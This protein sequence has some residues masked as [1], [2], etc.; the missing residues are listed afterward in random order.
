MVVWKFAKLVYGDRD[1][2][3]MITSGLE[4][5]YWPEEG[6]KQPS[7]MMESSMIL[8]S[9]NTGVYKSEKLSRSTLQICACYYR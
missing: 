1:Q 9:D 4:S 6:M 5:S 8:D 7:E 2:K 3:K